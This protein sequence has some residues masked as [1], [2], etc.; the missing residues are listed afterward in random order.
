M[1]EEIIR[2][3]EK[4]IEND[5]KNIDGIKF[6]DFV[7]I[8]PTSEEHKKQ[9]DEEL[10]SIAKVID[11]T[12]KGTFYLLNTPIVTKW[13]KLQF[14]KIRFFDKTRLNWECAPD[15]AIEDW[16]ALKQKIGIDEHLSFYTRKEWEA[17]EYK[18]DDSLIYFLNPLVS[19]IYNIK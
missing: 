19:K 3:N 9:L 2:I 10:K 4:R 18:S 17:I 5:I 15:F 16:E 12:E 1:L 14:L 8:F 13:G 6:I 7:D 11:T